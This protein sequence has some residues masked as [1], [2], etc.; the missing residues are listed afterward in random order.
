MKPGW[1]PKARIALR[2]C[3]FPAV[4]LCGAAGA[5]HSLELAA[6]LALLAFFTLVLVY[7]FV[8]ED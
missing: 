8:E 1:K 7:L 2:C 5:T 6:C 3:G 4:F